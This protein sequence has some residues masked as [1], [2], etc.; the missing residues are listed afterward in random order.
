MKTPFDCPEW[1]ERFLATVEEKADS[2][3]SSASTADAALKA[4]GAFSLWKFIREEVELE[5][6]R[7]TNL[8]KAQT[9]KLHERN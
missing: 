2:M 9:A 3:V 1:V 7:Q 4:T 8:L 6:V 5:A